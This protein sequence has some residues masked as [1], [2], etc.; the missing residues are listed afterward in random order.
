MI[1][2][3][4]M[5]MTCGGWAGGGKPMKKLLVL[6]VM[7][8][9][10]SSSLAFGAE[11]VDTEINPLSKST[12]GWGVGMLMSSP[13]A[14]GFTGEYNFGVATAAIA[15]GYDNLYGTSAF[16]LRMGGQY[17]FD[18]PFVNGNLRIY[19]SV[20]GHIDML[21]GSMFAFRFAAHGVLSAYLFKDL[22]LRMYIEVG[23]SILAT[24]TGGGFDL[25]ASI[26]ATY[27]L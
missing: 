4:L 25:Q 23:P 22:P 6:F 24:A 16:M 8:V 19:P 21:A 27:K 9:I 11:I 18:S 3:N 1:Y 12:Q 14:I 10:V 15:L 7:V 20:G 5:V 2:T 26:G 13:F 17:N